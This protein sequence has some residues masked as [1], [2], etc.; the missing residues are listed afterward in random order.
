MSRSSLELKIRPPLV[1]L[2]TGAIM[3]GLAWCSLAPLPGQA[4]WHLRLGM[5][6]IGLGLLLVLDAGRMFIRAKTTWKP[7]T[8]E[9]ASK[10]VT[11][12]AYRFSRNPMYL[13]MLLCLAGWGLGLGDWLGL[14]PL[15]LFVLYITLFQIIPE[16]R[17]LKG[18]FGEEYLEYMRR[19]RRWL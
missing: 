3:G 17:I 2:F 10:L 19:V 8:P 14:V 12:G 11:C 5:L 4:Q 18:L 7:G 9:K 6:L 16:E 15:P 1:G 13:G